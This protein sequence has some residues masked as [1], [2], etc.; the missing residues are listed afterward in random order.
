ELEIVH[1]DSNGM[2][3]V[4]EEDAAIPLSSGPQGG[5]IIFIGARAR[6]LD[7]CNLTISVALRD[8][9]DNHIEALDQRPETLEPQSDGWA[10]PAFPEQPTNYSALPVC[11]K[12]GQKHDIQGYRYLLHVTVKD[13]SGK[14]AE[15]SLNVTPVCPPGPDHND[16]LCDCRHEMP[17]DGFC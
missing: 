8:S 16:C 7:V 5:E 15:A 9:C 10:I 3:V 13:P 2:M 4:T 14:S 11:P 12:A 17:P 1:H 6:N